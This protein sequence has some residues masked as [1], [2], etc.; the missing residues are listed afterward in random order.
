[1]DARPQTS[2]RTVSDARLSEFQPLIIATAILLFF[3][4]IWAIVATYPIAMAGHVDFR[5][6]YTA[7]YMVRTGH[8]SELY[9]YARNLEFQN[10]QVGPAQGTLTFNHLAYEALFF[11]PLSY[12][13]YQRAYIVFFLVNL[14]VIAGAIRILWPYFSPLATIW[15]FLPAA[16]VACFLPVSIALAEGQDS[17]LLLALIVAAMTA[18]DQQKEVLGG[19]LLGLTLF[20]FQYALP[21]VLLF[22]VWRRWRF[23]AGFAISG[24]LAVALS[25]ALTGITAIREYLPYLLSIS[26]QST[27]ADAARHGIHPEGMAN[28]R[29]LAASIAGTSGASLSSSPLP[30]LLLTLLL[31]IAVLVWAGLKRPSLPLGLL[32]AILVSYHHVISDASLLIVPLGLVLSGAAVRPRRLTFLAGATYLGIPVL[33]FTG[34]HFSLLAVLLLALLAL[35]DGTYWSRYL[36]GKAFSCPQKDTK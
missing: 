7:G 9:S 10:Q 29:G 31:S 17:L 30:S 1:M 3:L 23:L 21:I 33:L 4:S 16:I 13:G 27:Q 5:H 20:K 32:V 19:V 26:A 15:R 14:L 25:L 24:T 18:V 11:A 35:W 28:L 8:G 12:L 2:S 6:L 22:L 34:L 36:D